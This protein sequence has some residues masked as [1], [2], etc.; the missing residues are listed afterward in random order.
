[1]LLGVADPGIPADIERMNAVMPGLLFAAVMNPAP[2][3]NIHIAVLADI[4]IVVDHLAQAGFCDNHRDMARLALCP[5]LDADIDASL[6]V[7]LAG[8]L[9]VFCGLPPV[10]A[11]VLPD[12]ERP[13]GFADQVRDFLQ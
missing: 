5:V 2:G 3:Y 7:G 10:A 8:N 13:H 4:E 9:N 11:G 6:A 1:M 12:I